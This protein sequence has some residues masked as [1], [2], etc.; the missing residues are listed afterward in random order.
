MPAV[1]VALWGAVRW[2]AGRVVVW[3]P[4]V[5]AWVIDVL[6]KLPG[7]KFAAACAIVVAVFYAIPW[8]A[9]FTGIGS[10]MDGLPPGIVWALNLLRFDIGVAI[11]ASAW[12]LRFVLRW[13]R[14]AVS[15]V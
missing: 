10:A 8:P 12:A 11:L 13:I 3:I 7:I 6:R 15:A 2:V 1:V 5:A 9:W 14:A 4:A